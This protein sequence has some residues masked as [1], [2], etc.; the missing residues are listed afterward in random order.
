MNKNKAEWETSTTNSP[1]TI[2][3]G[4]KPMYGI[5]YNH[6]HISREDAR[7]LIKDLEKILD[8]KEK[9]KIEHKI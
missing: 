9:L 4:F 2:Y 3:L 1:N 7:N 8:S 5:R 6:Y